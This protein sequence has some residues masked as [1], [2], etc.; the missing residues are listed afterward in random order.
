MCSFP[1]WWQFKKEEMDQGGTTAL[2]GR[3]ASRRVDFNSQGP[4]SRQ[5]A[6]WAALARPLHAAID[7]AN[8]AN[9]SEP[10]VYVV[11]YL[12]ESAK[13]SSGDI[14]KAVDS[15]YSLHM[16]HRSLYEDPDVTKILAEVLVAARNLSAEGDVFKKLSES[17]CGPCTRAVTVCAVTHTSLCA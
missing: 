9:V 7:A 12:L 1:D 4:L 6:V 3:I 10:T 17:G 15:R 13:G 14:R 2:Y 16:A 8:I 5:G 11:D